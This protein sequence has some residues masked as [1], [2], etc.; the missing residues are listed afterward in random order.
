MA[1]QRVNVKLLCPGGHEHG[2]CLEIPHEVHPDLRCKLEDPSGI[3][4]GG[5][6]CPLPSPD[7]LVARVLRGYRGAVQEW[8]RLG[9]VIVDLR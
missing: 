9:Y 1:G 6:G 5:G 3:S 2:V 8:R 4:A 7:E